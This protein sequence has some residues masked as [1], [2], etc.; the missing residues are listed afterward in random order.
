MKRTQGPLRVRVLA[1]TELKK[2]QGARGS[3]C[4]SVVHCDCGSVYTPSFGCGGDAFGY[5][6]TW[7]DFNCPACGVSAF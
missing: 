1:T 6:S 3:Y 5:F 2:A 7:G 4:G